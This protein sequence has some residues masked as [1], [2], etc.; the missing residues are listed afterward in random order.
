M[1]LLSSLS[2]PPPGSGHSS[3]T[4]FIYDDSVSPGTHSLLHSSEHQSI[5]NLRPFSQVWTE[6]GKFARARI[7]RQPSACQIPF[8]AELMARAARPVQSRLSLSRAQDSEDYPDIGLD[9]PWPSQTWLHII[10]G[11]TSN[12]NANF[13]LKQVA[14]PRSCL[15][16]SHRLISSLPVSPR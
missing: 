10:S 8:D 7:S 16:A 1:S 15:S 5:K 9:E 11:A 13:E 6:G 3:V 12:L 14:G 2:T 4:I